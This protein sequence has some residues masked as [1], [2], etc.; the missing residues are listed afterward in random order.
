MSML[1]TTNPP[2]NHAIYGSL[3]PN[4][5]CFGIHD[6]IDLIHFE[7]EENNEGKFKLKFNKDSQYM[8][9]GAC[10]NSFCNQDNTNYRRLCLFS[11]PKSALL[12]SIDLQGNDIGDTINNSNNQE[13]SSITINNSIKMDVSDYVND[14]SMYSM[15]SLESQS[16]ITPDQN[17]T[18]MEEQIL[19]G[20]EQNEPFE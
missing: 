6:N 15:Y 20:I 14:D 18:G 8:Y 5:L 2:N 1:K 3:A 19:S 17:V 9:I 7:L 11:D 10:I 12:F 4:Y 16:C 13:D